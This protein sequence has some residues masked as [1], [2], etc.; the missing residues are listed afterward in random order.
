MSEP[1]RVVHVLS[2]MD[3]AGAETLVMNL[4]RN[5]DKN[6]FQFDFV[7]HADEVGYFDDEIKRMGGKIHHTFKYRGKNH[8]TY[9][10]WWDDFFKSHRYSLVHCHIRSTA[11]IILS[12]AKKH[13]ITTIAH[14]HSSSNG[15][16]I[17]SFVKNTNQKFINRYCDYRIACS[18]EAGQF[19]FG[20]SKAFEILKNGIST[21]E[22]LFAEET[23]ENYRAENNLLTK[24]VYCHVGRFDKQKNHSFLIEIFSKIKEYDDDAHL[25]LI[26]DGELKVKIVAKVSQENLT[27]SVSFLGKRSNIPEIMMGSDIFLFPSLYEGLGIVLIEAQATGL[28]CVVSSDIPNEAIINE[29]ILSCQ[30]KDPNE[31]AK[32]ATKMIVLP[33]AELRKQA[34]K[35][36]V[37]AGYDIQNSVQRLEEIYSS[38]IKQF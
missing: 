18:K 30:L 3:Q 38:L 10:K 5:I 34:N 28:P 4:Y 15:T 12:M 24:K 21:Q 6:R 20:K 32:A 16:G 36:V 33:N 31:Y 27:D 29:E 14:S 37:E 26:G 23:R 13:N 25:L 11:N 19:L 17:R 2:K 7:V 1:I 22:F 35:S 9:K 8:R